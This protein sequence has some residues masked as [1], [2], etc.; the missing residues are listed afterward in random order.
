MK[1]LLADDHT[2]FRDTLLHYLERAKPEADV[3][4]AKG[5]DEVTEILLED[6]D[7]SLVLLD[8]RM[9]GMNGLDGLRYIREK[10]PNILVALM[11]GVAEAADVK[12]AIE[13]GAAG[14][15]PKTMS[16]KALLNGIELVLS[17]ERFMPLDQNGSKIMPSYYGDD[18]KGNSDPDIGDT[19]SNIENFDL[20]PREIDVLK[21]L[22]EGEAN[23]E[24][25]N[26]LG[27]QVV[28]V[29]LHVRGICRKLGVQNR[30]QAAL[31]AKEACI[32]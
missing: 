27:L 25:A 23:K 29:K 22:A 5:F 4:L 13:M 11:S 28:T 24:I 14:Y 1:L 8:Y 20:T 19:A 2:L 3:K 17:G 9:P 16:G 6:P 30:T 15:F 21:Y 10:Y 31:K 18:R 32:V 26:R 7:Q 12:N